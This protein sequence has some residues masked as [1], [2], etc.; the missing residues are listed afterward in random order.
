MGNWE[1]PP[2]ATNLVA[3]KMETPGVYLQTM[4]MTQ[5]NE[6]LKTNDLI[7][8]PV[9]STECHGAAQ[10]IGED[11]FLVTRMAEQVAAKT[12]CTVAM[13]VWYGSH[14]YNHLGMPGTVVVPEDVFLANLRAII[15]GLWNMGFRKQIFLNGHGQEEVIPLALHQWS[16]QYQVPSILIS[17]H[18]ETVIHDYLRDKAH[19]GK[20]LDT[21]FQHADEA[22][23]SYSLALFPE[24]CDMKLAVDNKPSGYLRPTDGF[25]H[26][27]GGGEVYHA[28]IKGHEHVGLSGIELAMYPEGV[29]G[30][31]TLAKA[32]KA[33]D[34]LNTLL[35]YMTRLINEIMEKFPAG[36][37]PPTEECT[38][39]D[40]KEVEALL[41]GP[42]KG[43]KH[44]YT[45]A[46]P[47]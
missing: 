16:K 35:D 11:T 20:Y 3:G 42:L 22:E 2:R 41:K 43:G 28:P 25:M 36:K 45:V 47:P 10:P 13:P 4:N 9:G 38:Q 32:E 24:F 15:A 8:I 26:I 18:W 46:Y 40:P 33:F 27:D 12:G 37:L 7:I 19:G 14:P 5:I 34:G 44:I 6:R 21:R 29:I 31:P 17:L 39:R 1:L 30:S 23:A